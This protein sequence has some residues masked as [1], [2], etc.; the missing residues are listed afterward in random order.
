MAQFRYRA[1]APSGELVVGSMEAPDETEVLSRLQD[2]SL[3]PVAAE[4][5]GSARARWWDRPVFVRRSLSDKQ[6][7]AVTRQL[8]R[9]ARAGLPVERCLEIL[10][11]VAESKGIEQTLSRILN[12]IRGG[13]TLADAFASQGPPFNATYVSMIRAGEAGSALPVVI[14][15]LS[16][17]H[18]R[19]REFRASMV[20]ALI[21]PTVL[22][23]VSLAS[24]IVLLAFVVPQFHQ[25]FEDSAKALPLSTT[26]VIW[27]AEK[28]RS[29]WWLPLGLVLAAL[30]VVPWM[31]H[32]P[33]WWG[34]DSILRPFYCS[35]TAGKTATR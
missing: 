23:V 35:P 17:Y 20:S 12:G 25:L 10:I 34:R 26:V 28:L 11:L 3:L 16:V 32:V 1:I 29:F 21:Y 18:E 5:A 14:E 24:V 7:G 2:Q 27:L 13:S 6:L 19:A 22:V 15:R 30:M 4:P 31:L 9:L 33:S 8:A